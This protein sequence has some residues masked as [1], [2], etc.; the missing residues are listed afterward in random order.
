MI[1][2]D[3][4]GKGKFEK[5]IANIAIGH[6]TYILE[7]VLVKLHVVSFGPRNN[8]FEIMLEFDY[9]FTIFNG[10]AET[11]IICETPNNR[12]LD[13]IANIVDENQEAGH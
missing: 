1:L 4:G 13:T 9:I 7:L 2:E 6:V 8:T 3:L 12:V 5:R 10:L 11:C